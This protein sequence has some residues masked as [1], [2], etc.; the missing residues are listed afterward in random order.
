MVAIKRKAVAGEK[1]KKRTRGKKKKGRESDW[2]D[3]GGEKTSLMQT[4]KQTK[5][6]KRPVFSFVSL[7]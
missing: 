3:D 2:S 4:R 6:A 5:M 7:D 1:R